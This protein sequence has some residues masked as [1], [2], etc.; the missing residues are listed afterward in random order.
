MVDGDLIGDLVDIFSRISKQEVDMTCWTIIE[1]DREAISQNLGTV[2]AI[3]CFEMVEDLSPF[4]GRESRNTVGTF[5]LSF[6]ITEQLNLIFNVNVLVV[7]LFQL[8]DQF[9]FKLSFT[10]YGHFFLWLYSWMC[11]IHLTGVTTYFDA[12]P[13][14]LQSDVLSWFT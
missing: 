9:I 3:A 1:S 7:E 10:L 4:I 5:N 2:E 11:E 8:L 12:L 13:S 6:E 14:S